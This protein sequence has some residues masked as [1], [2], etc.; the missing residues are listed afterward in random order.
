MTLPTNFTNDSLLYDVHPTAH[1]NTNAAVNAL[2]AVQAWQTA[3]LTPPTTNFDAATFNS[4]G[5]FK[6]P[7][8]IVHLRGVVRLSTSGINPTLFVLPAGY[9]PSK[10][11]LFGTMIYIGAARGIGDLRVLP[12]GTVRYEGADTPALLSLDGLTFRAV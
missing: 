5:Y 12:A 9:W 1:N 2:T 7:F 10:T 11:E 4:A 8:G 3:T 6:D